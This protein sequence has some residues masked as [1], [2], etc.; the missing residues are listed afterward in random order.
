MNIS[1]PTMWMITAD[2]LTLTMCKGKQTWSIIACLATEWGIVSMKWVIHV[3]WRK[4]TEKLSAFLTICKECPA[5]SR[6]FFAIFPNRP[7]E[8]GR[9]NCAKLCTHTH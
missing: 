5:S 6:E 1:Q 8:G 4:D 9:G 2:A 7:W 3:A